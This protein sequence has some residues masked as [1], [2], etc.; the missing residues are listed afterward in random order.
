MEGNDHTEGGSEFYSFAAKVT[1]VK[2]VDMAY[3]KMRIKFADATHISCT[4]RFADPNGLYDQGYV[5]DGEEGQG[6]NVLSS[7]KEREAKEICVFI[8]RYFVK[9]HLGERRFEIGK[10]LTFNAVRKL[11]I[12]R[13][14]QNRR[15]RLERM[16]SMQSLASE[17]SSAAE[18]GLSQDEE[19]DIGKEVPEVLERPQGS[20]KKQTSASAAD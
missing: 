12:A 4:Y 6:R 18:D 1:T 9:K 7:L 5:D 14:S 13:T 17:I 10:D 3:K 11:K 19:E 15:H 2:E 8:V 16:R 20:Q